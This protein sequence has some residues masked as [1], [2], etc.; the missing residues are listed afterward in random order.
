MRMR[1][2]LRTASATKITAALTAA[3]TGVRD[4]I[5]GNDWITWRGTGY[6]FSCLTLKLAGLPTKRADRGRNLR[7]PTHEKEYIS[8]AT[9]AHLRTR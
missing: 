6:G 5:E 3:A 9:F 1:V 7:A 8:R 2:R 4:D